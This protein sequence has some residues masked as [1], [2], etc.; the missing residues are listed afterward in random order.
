MNDLR[1]GI[2]DRPP[3]ESLL[4]RR[5]TIR[6]LDR[7]ALAERNLHAHTED[8]IGTGFTVQGLKIRCQPPISVDEMG[9]RV[10]DDP[11]TILPQG[12]RNGYQDDSGKG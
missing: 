5:P 11:Q 6:R 9:A 4:E 7:P 3:E 2:V 12:R 10:R 1:I 8:R